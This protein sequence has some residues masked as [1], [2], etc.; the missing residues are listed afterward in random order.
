MD[1]IRMTLEVPSE[2]PTESVHL[3]LPIQLVGQ[4]DAF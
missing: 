2:H 4:A 1:F 3:V